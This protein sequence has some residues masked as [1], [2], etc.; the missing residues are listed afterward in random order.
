[1]SFTPKRIVFARHDGVEKEY[2]FSVPEQM[3]IDIGDL[4]LVDTS[5][6]PQVVTASSSI[7]SGANLDQVAKR[8]GA[9]F[10][11][12]EVL[13]VCGQQMRTYIMKQAMNKMIAEMKLKQQQVNR[14]VTAYECDMPHECET[15]TAGCKQQ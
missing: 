15:C 10:P 5:R 3:R 4:L 14:F 8:F 11:L 13:Q 9:T 6:G 12:R 1:M 2:V 7:I